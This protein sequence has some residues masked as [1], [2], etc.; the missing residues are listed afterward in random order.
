MRRMG[1]LA[2]VCLCVVA[3]T[4]EADD[5]YRGPGWYVIA[6]QYAAVIW[7]GPYASQQACEAAKPADGDP[8]GFSYDC[9]YLDHDPG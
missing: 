4:V 2:A 3:T 5:Y 1:I 8:P 7:S 9:S 6:Y